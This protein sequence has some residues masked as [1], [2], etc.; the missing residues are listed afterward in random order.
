MGEDDNLLKERKRDLAKPSIQQHKSLI[1]RTH[2]QKKTNK[3]VLKQSN[4]SYVY[5]Q[6]TRTI[7]RDHGFF[8]HNAG[9][10]VGTTW[11]KGMWLNY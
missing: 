11:G 5:K 9:G 6:F 3:I 2:D 8:F 7:L 10:E 4:K 1:A